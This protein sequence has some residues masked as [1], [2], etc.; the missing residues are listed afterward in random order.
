MGGADYLH[1]AA[2]FLKGRCVSLIKSDDLATLHIHR[3]IFHDVPKRVRGLESAPVLSEIEATLD[4][5]RIAHLKR[6][7]VRRF[8]SD[9]GRY[10]PDESVVDAAGWCDRCGYTGSETVCPRCG[11]QQL[12]PLTQTRIEEAIYP[13]V[14]QNIKDSL[15]H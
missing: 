6:R 9:C 14:H 10:G 13:Y 12:D 1:V 2:S 7:L 4:E 15:V 8:C 11:P 3:L 5:D